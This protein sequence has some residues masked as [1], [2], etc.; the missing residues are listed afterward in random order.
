MSRQEEIETVM[1]YLECCEPVLF[2]ALV[3]L[4]AVA[5]DA[6]IEETLKSTPG[7]KAVVPSA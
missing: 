5:A 4:A 2:N 6:S 3:V 1:N 7:P